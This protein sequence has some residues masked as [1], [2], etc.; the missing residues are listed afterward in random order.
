MSSLTLD[1]IEAIESLK[2]LISDL[3]EL[4]QNQHNQ[5]SIKTLNTT[6]S[7]FKEVQ[8][9]FYSQ[10]AKSPNTSTSQSGNQSE[11]SAF[12]KIMYSI[13]NLFN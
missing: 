8:N 3:L 1:D 11:P 5:L 9:A 10:T 4:I 12:V 2:Q 13:Y 7:N 6:N